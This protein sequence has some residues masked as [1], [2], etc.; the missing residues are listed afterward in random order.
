MSDCN[1]CSYGGYVFKDAKESKITRN[2]ADGKVHEVRSY[3][4]YKDAIKNGKVVIDFYASWCGPCKN[5]AP[6]FSKAAQKHIGQMKYFKIDGGEVEDVATKM[7]IKY[8]PTF[9][10]YIDGKFKDR[11][12]TGKLSELLKFLDKCLLTQQ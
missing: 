8:Y 4:A 2:V 7:E 10:F 12:V 6:E 1:K 9:I 5:L 11:I 3:S